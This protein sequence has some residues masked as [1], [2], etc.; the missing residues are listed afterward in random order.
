MTSV[1]QGRK[2]ASEDKLTDEW[3]NEKCAAAQHARPRRIGGQVRA[4]PKTQLPP[5]VTIVV[6]TPFQWRE[7]EIEHP[8]KPRQANHRDQPRDFLK[9]GGLVRCRDNPERRDPNKKDYERAKH[10]ESDR[11]NRYRYDQPNKGETKKAEGRKK[12]HTVY[13]ALN[14]TE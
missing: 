2:S 10:R 13:F 8:S 7:K 12:S 14:M 3:N 6:V 9:A 11:K 5:C 4:P 1:V